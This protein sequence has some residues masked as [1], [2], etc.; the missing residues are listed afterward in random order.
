M[1]MM[2]VDVCVNKWKE[3][4][5]VARDETQWEL[6]SFVERNDSLESVGRSWEEIQ[7][8]PGQEVT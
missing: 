2:C 3:D 5:S 7:E 1:M 6:V 8:K 4:K